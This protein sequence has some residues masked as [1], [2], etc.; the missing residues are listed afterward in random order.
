[1]LEANRVCVVTEELA[2]PG[3]IFIG[4][5]EVVENLMKKLLLR[6]FSY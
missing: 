6:V 3:A 4:G 1:M 5:K 2:V